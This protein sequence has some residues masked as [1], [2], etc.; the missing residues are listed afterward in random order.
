MLR[1]FASLNGTFALPKSVVSSAF[2]AAAVRLSY[3]IS[4]CV[5]P[6]DDVNPSWWFT[7]AMLRYSMSGLVPLKFGDVVVAN[8]PCADA[9]TPRILGLAL[10]GSSI[11]TT[12][13]SQS[14]RCP[15]PGEGE[16]CWVSYVSSLR[17]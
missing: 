11:Q 3:A 16:S 17:A 8:P 1:K 12:M 10:L 2:R 15:S 6:T 5:P 4:G 14:C 7:G 13:P 9:A